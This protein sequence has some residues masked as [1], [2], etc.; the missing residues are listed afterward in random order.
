MSS[1]HGVNPVIR[2]LVVD[3]DPVIRLLACQ[4]L[5]AMGMT[6]AEAENGQDA[7]AILENT[8]LS[9]VILDVELP[10]R[11][12]LEICAE[13]RA[14]A[15]GREIPILIITG[16]EDSEVIER[17]FEVGATDFIGKPIDW[18]LLQ[19]RVR[20]LMR[21]QGAI[22]ELR[23][24]HT[25]LRESEARLANAQRLARIGNWEWVPGDEEMLWS[26]QIHR[27]F[28]IPQGPGVS[29]LENFLGVAHPDDREG[30]EK[31]INRAAAES[32]SWSLDHR[33]VLPEGEE[34][35]VR[36]QAEVVTGPSGE[37]YRIS[38]T[39]QDITDR[40][41][42][43]EQLRYLA[44]Y[45]DLTALPNRKMMLEQ[46]D[47]AM[48]RAEISKEM[49]GLLFLDLDRFKRIND[50]FGP[51]LGDSVLKAVADR[52]FECVRY[53]DYISRAQPA[54]ATS[55]SRVGGDEFAILL[56][57][58]SS[59]E[60]AAHVSQ[61]IMDELRVPF[62]VDGQRLDL[63]VTL[64][65]ALYP[66]DGSDAET[67]LRN[68]G[69]A[70]DQAKALSHNSC[71]FFDESMNKRVI[72]NMQ[73]ETGLRSAI[74]RDELR[75]HYQ[76]QIDAH[77]GEIVSV[78]ALV[79][80]T[81]SEL[82]IINPVEFIP[83]AEESGLIFTLGE[84]VLRTACTQIRAWHD[85]GLPEI[86]VAVNVSSHQLKQGGF[87]EVVERALR[88]ANLDTKFLELE[89]TESAVI[90]TEPAVVATLK[91]LRG[92]GIR[93]ALDD[94]GTGCSSLSDL[95]EFPITN[96]KIDQSFVRQIGEN[97]HANAITAAVL[98][99]G[100]NLSLSV[101]AEGVE[102]EPQL[103]FLRARRCDIYQGYLFSR[104]LAAEKLEN[105]LRTPGGIRPLPV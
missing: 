37:A 76:P 101:T 102:T 2:V 53:T 40:F 103:E 29:T 60:D 94:F 43:E 19:H 3:D 80:W 79:R 22:S 39:M 84:W 73:L 28:E 89:I 58:L 91:R 10:G 87:E 100:H 57:G 54:D 98:A 55:L 46:I 16:R 67:L 27:I 52:L 26:D 75:V 11:N 44:Y 96:L 25:E 23:S 77:S 62:T 83:V 85:A 86:G 24:M 34:R 12:G 97:Q 82:G 33:I 45:D 15:A 93:L 47:R 18:Q 8:P 63:T 61:R 32:A 68:A 74:E 56:N 38:G 5:S 59:S 92:M 41:R 70:L 50:M 36:Q 72:R 20:F 65:I 6:P 104:P 51:Q 13:M 9:L 17:A 95:V 42:A 99:M 4:S 14:L 1:G 105:L 69:V 71:Q 64:G 90:G 31:A 66:A 88:D 48:R 81:S 78:E 21:A 35:V 49:V 7:L 30:L